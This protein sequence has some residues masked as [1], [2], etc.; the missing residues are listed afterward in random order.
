MY[1]ILHCFMYMCMCE[2]LS[3]DRCF[4]TPC[5]IALQAPLPMEYS[6]QEYWSG[7]LFPSPEDLPNPGN[8]PRSSTLR[9]DSLQSEP[10]G[11][12]DLKIDCCGV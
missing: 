3:R 7:F 1:L 9:A 4:A 10:P 8:E 6:R 11:Y 2:S 12:Q 5:T